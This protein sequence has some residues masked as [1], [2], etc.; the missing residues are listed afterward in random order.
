MQWTVEALPVARLEI[1]ALP[2]GL[3]ARL[4]RLMQ[5]IEVHGLD[6]VHEPHA[7]HLERKLWELRAEAPEGIARALCHGDRAAR[8]GAACLCEKVR[9]NPTRRARPCTSTHEGD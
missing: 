6:Q 5:L 3:R 9:Q 8:R 7:K 4:L 1:V 2:V